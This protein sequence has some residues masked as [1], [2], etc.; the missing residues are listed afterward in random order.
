MVCRIEQEA[1]SNLLAV[2]KTKRER[3]I[4]L[5][6]IYFAANLGVR[7]GFVSCCPSRAENEDYKV[8][9]FLFLFE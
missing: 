5:V 7:C 9:L 4:N 1:S 3:K 8:D 6:F 2:E